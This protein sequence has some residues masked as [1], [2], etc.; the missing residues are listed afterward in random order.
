MSPVASSSS[1]AAAAA[2]SSSDL[3]ARI[4]PFLDRQLTYAKKDILS[5]K[6]ALLSR[7][8]MVDFSNAIYHELNGSSKKNEPGFE[9]RRADVVARLTGLQDEVAPVLE[10]IQDPA[11]VQQ[12]KQDKIA[13]LQYLR[14]KHNFKPEMLDTLFKFAHLQYDVGNYAGASESLYHFRILSSDTDRNTAAIWGK[15]A[16]DIMAKNWDGAFEELMR[17]REVIDQALVPTSGAGIATAAAAAKAGVSVNHVQLQQRVWLLHWALF[18]FFNHP[19]GKDALVDLFMSP[20]YLN[21]IQTAAPWLLRYV[22]AGIIINKRRRNQLKDLIGIIRQEARVYSDPVTEFLEALYID[23]DFDGAQ[24]KLK[25]CEAVL[26]ADFFLAPIRT[27]FLES[28]RFFV[29][30]MYCRINQ[31]IDIASLSAKLNMDQDMGEKWIVN[32]IRDARMQAKIDSE[33]VR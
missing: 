3:T 4:S 11:L 15:L 2:S 28:A 32:L 14:E 1:S 7:T 13:N 22:A 23:F 20:A 10:I 27:E 31:R 24:Q 9:R 30:E 18:V 29:F 33:T 19:R 17:L 25:G 8:S 16:A 12:L 6:H 5:A 26:D 21:A